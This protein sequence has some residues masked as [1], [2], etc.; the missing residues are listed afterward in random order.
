[1]V[2]IVGRIHPYVLIRSEWVIEQAVLFITLVVM[3]TCSDW[4]MDI[5]KQRKSKARERAQRHAVERITGY[6]RWKQATDKARRGAHSFTRKLSR[7]VSRKRSPLTR[8]PEE[9]EVLRFRI[10]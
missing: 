5:K 9:L 2:V 3:F 1:M 6:E 10:L 8:T 4:L 7:S